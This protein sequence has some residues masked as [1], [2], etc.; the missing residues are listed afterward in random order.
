[1]GIVVAVLFAAR[2]KN[3]LF[4][5]KKPNLVGFSS[6]IGFVVGFIG[7]ALFVAEYCQKNIKQGND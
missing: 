7:Q 5:K 2:L 4:F 1:L 6:F 3:L